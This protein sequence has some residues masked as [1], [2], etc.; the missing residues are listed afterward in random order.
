MK[1]FF[2]AALS[3]FFVTSMALAQTVPVSS[4]RAKVTQTIGLAEVTIDYARPSAKERTVFGSMVPF[5]E[6]WRTGANKATSIEV[7]QTIAVGNGC[8]VEP[9]I[10]SIF[11][12][13]GEREWQLLINTETEL[14]GTRGYKEENTVCKTVMGAGKIDNHVETFQISFENVTQS[15]ADLTFSWENT[16]A[17]VTISHDP[18]EAAVANIQ[19]AIR[20][21]D[22][23]TGVYNTA[24][25]FYLDFN[26]D[27]AK[28]LEFAKKAVEADK[29]NRFWV[30]TTLAKAYAANKDFK[31]AIATAEKAADMAKKA[32]SNAY[33]TMNEELIK[34]WKSVKK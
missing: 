13:P 31:N 22:N 1:K 16:K 34:Q 25:N 5:G 33:V 4:P 19:K 3:T 21:L 7:T 9:G 10:Y 29:N 26:V 18:V 30:M 27:N 11:T 32:N 8:R 28:A 17:A 2:T 12:I 6:M 14:W 20:D 15:T 24:A 23:V